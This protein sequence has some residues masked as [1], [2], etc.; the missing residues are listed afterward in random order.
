[1]NNVYMADSLTEDYIVI[2]TENAIYIS[3]NWSILK[4]KYSETID[5]I[6]NKMC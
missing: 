1:M 5:R 2:K 4:F 6:V 3:K